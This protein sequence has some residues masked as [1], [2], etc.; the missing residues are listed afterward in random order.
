[1]K[2]R[3]FSMLVLVF[4]TLVMFA[5]CSSSSDYYDSGTSYDSEKSTGE[6]IREQL[7]DGPA[8]AYY[9]GE[10]RYNALTGQ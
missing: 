8:D 9:E 7:G 10:R 6:V 3:K 2:K 4:V 1:M 5:G